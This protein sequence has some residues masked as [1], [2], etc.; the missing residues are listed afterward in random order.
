[1]WAGIGG[2]LASLPEII[3]L[4][5]AL[6][7]WIKKISGNDPKAFIK[8]L[9]EVFLQI[10]KAESQDDKQKAALALHNLIAKL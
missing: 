8:N 1:M 6:F 9:N 10:N 2:L 7:E 4:A 3:K 5:S